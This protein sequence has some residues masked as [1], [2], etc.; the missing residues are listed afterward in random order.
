[1]IWTDELIAAIDEK[2]MR[3]GLARFIAAGETSAALRQKAAEAAMKRV[4]ADAELCRVRDA[5][6]AYTEAGAKLRQQV[7]EGQIAGSLARRQMAEHWDSID[8]AE[9]RRLVKPLLRDF[10]L[11]TA[12]TRRERAAAFLGDETGEADHQAYFGW[13][14]EVMVASAPPAPQPAAADESVG[15]IR[16]ALDPAP[17]PLRQCVTRFDLTP[18]EHTTASGLAILEMS[19]RADPPPG[20]RQVTWASAVTVLAG[21]GGTQAITAVGKQA[22]WGKG[23]SSLD[24]TATI[25]YRCG[26]FALGFGP[27]GGTASAE[28]FV[29]VF[30]D[31]G[32]TV[33]QGRMLGVVVA[34][35]FWGASANLVGQAQVSVRVALPPGGGRASLYAGAVC[36]A[37]AGGV[38][39]AA[40][41]A[42]LSC[43]VS[44]LCFSLS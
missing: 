22:T 3:S 1:M 26:L 37:A 7:Q 4:E 44:E 8:T 5:L 11:Q 28:V 24:L 31:N 12:A 42:F 2:S 39:S 13:F 25:D 41:D 15:T 29:E 27:N 9:T 14:G 23:Y 21:G 6:V 18:R 34:P 10:E 17:P 40:G 19:A 38:L 16:Q 43:N 32:P 35:V 33:R 20:G 30:V 36:S